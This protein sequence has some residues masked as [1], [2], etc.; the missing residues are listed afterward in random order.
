MTPTKKYLGFASDNNSRVHPDVL[1]A[2]CK[3]NEGYTIGYGDDDYTK[4]AINKIKNVFGKTIEVYF[5]FNGTAANV[6]GLN[7]V[8]NSYNSIICSTN[9]HI[10][11]DEC[12]A[13]ERITGCKLIPI[14]TT[15]GKL[16]VDLIKDHITGEDD[17]H[18]SASKIISVTQSTELGTVYSVAELKEITAFAH[19]NNLLVHMDG[20][21]L[22]NAAA[23]L[24]TSL[25]ELTT[26]VGIDLLSLGGTKNGMMLGEAV[27]FF[28]Q[29]SQKSFKHVRKQSMQLASKMRFIAVQFEALL[30]NDLWLKNAKT[31]NNT[32]QFLKQKLLEIPEIKIVQDV[33]VNSIFV[34]L[35]S[36][37]IP[38]LQQE[39]FFY[40]WNQERSEVRFMTSFDTTQ[41]DV[42]EFISLIKKLS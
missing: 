34:K 2:I 1:Q 37:W 19:K 42:L 14:Q 39:Q 25:K 6:L 7:S 32:A 16:T 21:R 27:I 24:N 10:N 40:V 5:V 4:S 23:A 12:G 35:P 29:K 28:N 31:A 22:Y 15:N 3:A 9:A 11:T 30:T 33:Q 13:P 38:A 26:D 20:A 41:D 18:H 17:Q 36:K 8:T